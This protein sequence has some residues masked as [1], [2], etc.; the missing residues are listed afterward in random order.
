VADEI[1]PQDPV[2][3]IVD[4]ELC[5]EFQ[6]E[7][8]RAS[9]GGYF[10]RKGKPLAHMVWKAAHG[11]IPAGH[12]IHHADN[13]HTNNALVNLEC[14]TKKDHRSRHKSWKNKKVSGARA[15]HSATG[16]ALR[17]WRKRHEITAKEA[18]ELLGMKWTTLSQYEAGRRRGFSK[19]LTWLP[20]L[21]RYVEM[22]G[23]IDR[24]KADRKRREEQAKER[25][26]TCGQTIKTT[27]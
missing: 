20:K 24:L 15:A 10:Q 6:G 21:F 23:A 11:V 19:V 3:V 8:Y 7:I 16:D 22:D 18:A 17:E 9:T 25:C 14:L 4:G 27:R 13:N 1:L 5:Q 26:P 12:E 2:S